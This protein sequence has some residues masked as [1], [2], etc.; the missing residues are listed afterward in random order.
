MPLGQTKGYFVFFLQSYIYGNN[1]II[2][3]QSYQFWSVRL[4]SKEI[5]ENICV[6]IQ[7]TLECSRP[8]LEDEQQPFL[9]LSIYWVLVNRFFQGGLLCMNSLTLS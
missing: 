4:C 3:L 8:A 5:Q 2:Y 1:E 9:G 6:D 7:T